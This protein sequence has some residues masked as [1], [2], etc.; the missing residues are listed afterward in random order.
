MLLMTNAVHR[1]NALP[2]LSLCAAVALFSF[3]RVARAET[4]PTRECIDAHANGQVLR[5]QGRLLQAKSEF[6]SCAV[7]SCPQVIRDD[8]TK[9]GAEVEASLPSVVVVAQSSAGEDIPSANVTIDG[10]APT[11]PVDGRAIFVDPGTH[12]FNLTTP[13]GDKASVTTVIREAEKY[14]RVVVRVAGQ[15]Q[16]SEKASPQPQK[17]GVSPLVYVF[18]GTAL[19]GAGAFTYFALDGRHRENQLDDCAPDC[20]RSDVKAMRRSY[21]AADVSLG[22]AVAS[23]GL[24]TYFLLRGRA[25]EPTQP[26]TALSVSTSGGLSAWRVSAVTSF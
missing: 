3:G 5:G 1:M 14:R 19:L 2:K 18:G 10:R 21:L 11:L 26:S 8:C 13:A 15:A 20:A 9:F 16:P 7:E 4:P 6:L 23:L 25:S 22:V 12:V 17:P 24:G